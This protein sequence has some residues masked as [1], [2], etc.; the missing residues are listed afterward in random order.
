MDAL[1]DGRVHT[2]S[3]ILAQKRASLKL[4]LD[5]NEARNMFNENIMKRIVEYL[6]SGIS[7]GGNAEARVAMD[8]S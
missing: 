2:D 1:L 4:I 3:E 6:E 7:G 5:Q 8:T